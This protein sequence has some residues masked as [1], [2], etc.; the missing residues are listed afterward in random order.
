[1]SFFSKLNPYT[2]KDKP[3]EGTDPNDALQA[4]PVPDG[5]DGPHVAN[6][7]PSKEKA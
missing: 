4:A 5:V 6:A 2:I 1:M 7:Q 3:A